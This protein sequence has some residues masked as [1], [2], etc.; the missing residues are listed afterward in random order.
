MLKRNLAVV[1]FLF[2]A[3]PQAF[4]NAGVLPP[5]PFGVT[6]GEWTA[7]WWEFMVSIPAPNNP[8]LDTTGADCGI[9]QA[10]PVW[11]LEG[12]VLPV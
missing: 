7:R 1:V 8:I 2:A 5:H 12:Q 11:F 3:L 10:G 6:Y 9:A 4:G